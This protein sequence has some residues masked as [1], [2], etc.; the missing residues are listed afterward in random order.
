MNAHIIIDSQTGH[1]QD[2]R[3]SASYILLQDKLLHELIRQARQGGRV[4]RLTVLLSTNMSILLFCDSVGPHLSKY[5]Q[6]FPGSS[7][8]LK[9]ILT[10]GPGIQ[11]F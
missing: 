5:L 6:G 10:C 4:N 7:K 2:A 1:A 3:E 8:D 9:W 11:G